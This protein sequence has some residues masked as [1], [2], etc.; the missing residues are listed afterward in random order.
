MNFRIG[1]VRNRT[2][3]LVH[4]YRIGDRSTA[5]ELETKLA[6]IFYK[7]AGDNVAYSTALAVQCDSKAACLR[8]REQLLRLFHTL[9]VEP[10]AAD[11][12]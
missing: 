2:L 8:E 7:L 3:A 9:R 12:P 4:S 6:Q 5:G 11:A 10:T 1:T